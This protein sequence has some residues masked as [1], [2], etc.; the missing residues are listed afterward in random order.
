MN[1]VKTISSGSYVAVFKVD[2][3]DG[4]MTVTSHLVLPANSKFAWKNRDV[5]DFEKWRN[6]SV[7]E[8][9]RLKAIAESYGEELFNHQNTRTKWKYEASLISICKV[10]K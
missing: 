8:N 4:G 7:A 2:A 10:F 1:I 9:K 6:E 5:D 3:I